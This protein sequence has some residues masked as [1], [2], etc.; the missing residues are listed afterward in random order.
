MYLQKC[1]EKCINQ[2]HIPIKQTTSSLNV[3][4]YHYFSNSLFFYN[5]SFSCCIKDKIKH[6][7][8]YINKKKIYSNVSQ[9]DTTQWSKGSNYNHLILK[10]GNQSLTKHLS[11]NS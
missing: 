10:N 3:E 4:K 5:Q 11:K 8:I 6:V 9:L 7:S 1:Q 2:N